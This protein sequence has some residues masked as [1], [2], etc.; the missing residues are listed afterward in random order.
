M[1]P[2]DAKRI[3][4]SGFRAARRALV[5]STLMAWATWGSFLQAG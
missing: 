3:F 2:V 4:W 1:L 5:P